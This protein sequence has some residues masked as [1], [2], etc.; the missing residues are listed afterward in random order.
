VLN[1]ERVSDIPVASGN[2]L[3]PMFDWRQMQRWG[4]SESRLPADAIV[5][6]RE[7]TLWSQYKVYVAGAA[8]IVLLQGLSIGGP[9]VQRSRR[10]RVEVRLQQSEEVHRLTLGN[11]SDAVFITKPDGEFTFICPNVHVIF[12]WSQAEAER[13]GNICG[14]LGERPFDTLEALDAISNLECRI[15]DKAGRWHDLLVS[16]KRVSIGEGTDL[17]TCRDITDRR[18]A[19]EANRNL[20]HAQRLAGMGELTAM[21]AHEVNQP[22]GAILAN[23]EAAE[24]L[25]EADDPPLHEVREILASIRRND[26]RADEAIRR[27]RALLRRQEMQMVPLD[28]NETVAE[29]LKLAASD[30]LRRRI[31]I[32]SA[33]ARSLPLVSADPVHLQ[34]LLLNLIVNAMDAMKDV[35]ESARELTVRTAGGGAEDTVEVSV[36]DRGHGIPEDKLQRIFE[37]F[38]TTKPD[39]MGLGLTIARTIVETHQGRIWVENNADGG[40]TFHFALPVARVEAATQ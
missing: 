13:M 10:R 31:Q 5:R 40:A 28:L 33:P 11:I 20:A 3:T 35:P 24:M 29:V 18:R 16:V 19:E 23:A 15:V 32:R 9:L 4:I 25:L 37:S 8:S 30:A 36:V 17:Y 1:G 34:Q 27:I 6:F 22:L 38:F 2:V 39:G 14:L 12:G 26:L 7:P 21:V